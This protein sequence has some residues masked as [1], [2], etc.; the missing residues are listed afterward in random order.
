MKKQ[1]KLLVLILFVLGGIINI[2]A[3]NQPIKNV[4]LVHGAFVD[5][6][7]WESVYQILTQKGYKVFV[8]QHTLR[9]LDDDIIDVNRIINQLDGP[10]ILVGHSFGG[11]IISEAGNNPKVKG[12]VFVAAHAPESGEM[13][14]QL[15]KKY[16]S[17]YKSLIKGSDGFDYILPEKFPEDFAADLPL[18]K[19]RFMAYSQIPTA[20][21]VFNTPIQNPAWKNK[22]NWY[23][24][25]GADRIIN[26]DLERFYALRAKSKKIVEVA[27]ASHAVYASSPKEVTELIEEATS[28]FK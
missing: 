5:G 22:P 25:A 21:I 3:Q 7:G 10:C 14:S 24:V 17:A 15:V 9:N 2:S 8:T 19:A 4:V 13:R 1:K 27:G 16:P 23:L 28:Y 6:S 20:D 18:D 12:L 11:V 26:P